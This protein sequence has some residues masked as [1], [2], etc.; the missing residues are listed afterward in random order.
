MNITFI[1]SGAIATAIGHIL[2]IKNEHKIRLLSIEEDVIESINEHRINNKYF[3][4]VKLRKT[5]KAT[6]DKTILKD[7]YIIFLSIPSSQT[8]NYIKTNQSIINPDAILVNL[9]KGFGDENKTIVQCLKD[10]CSNPIATMKGPSFA[11]DIINK[12]HT[13]LTVGAEDYKVFHELKDVFKKTNIYL[14][15]SDDI[16][17]VELLS[18]LKNIYAIAMGIVDAHHDSPNLRF[19]VLTNAFR[20]MRS[21]LIQFGGKE[22]TL[23]NYCGFGDFG[24]TALNDLS[25]N[26]TL[27]LL[28]G[29]GFFSRDISDNVLLEGRIAVNVFC[30]EISKQN[31]LTDFHIINELYKVFN[32][33]YDISKFLNNILED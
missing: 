6:S 23:F 33:G 16:I 18:I 1:G 30:E 27:G 19:L 20:E 29:K 31:S 14:D 32:N 28:I 9:A 5:L 2:A 22:E 3:P 12:Q 15:H 24:L 25:R 8:V 11:R 10:V 17:G 7:A 21:L 13:G 4:N 26:R